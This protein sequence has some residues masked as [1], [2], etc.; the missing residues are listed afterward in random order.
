KRRVHHF[1]GSESSISP[2]HVA[3]GVCSHELSGGIEPKRLRA[4]SSRFFAP[5]AFARAARRSG[6][7]RSSRFAR[8]ALQESWIE[9]RSGAGGWPRAFLNLE[10]ATLEARA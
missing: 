10:F 8:G 9:R 4:R 3:G 5:T 7:T 6:S 1:A 2:R